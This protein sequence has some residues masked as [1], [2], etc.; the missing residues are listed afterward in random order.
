MTHLL[1]GKQSRAFAARGVVRGASAQS[2][3]D[4]QEVLSV[5]H[6]VRQFHPGIGGMENFVEQLA[7]RQRAAGHFVRVVTLDRIFDDPT[8]ARLPKAEVRRGIEIV[9]LPF[10]GSARYSIAPGVL[11]CIR[12]ADIVHVHGV[13]FFCD[14]LAATSWLHQKPMVISTHG[15]FFH[16]NFMRRF[17]QFYFNVATRSSMSQYGAVIACSEEDRRTFERVAGSRLTLIS[18]PVDV[19]KFAG[20]AD[21]SARNLIYFGRLAPNKELFRLIAWF[22]GLVSRGDWR[23]IIAG[24]P[25]GISSEQLIGEARIKG[26]ADRLEVHEAPTD[27]ILADLISRSTAYC[28]SSSY[29]GFGLAAIEAASAGLFPVL[30]DIPAFRDNVE[31]LGFGILIDF[32]DSSTWETSYERF[33]RSLGDFRCNLSRDD[34]RRKVA[35]F[36]WDGAAHLFEDVYARVLGRSTRRIGSVTVD[37]AD[38]SSATAAILD[39]AQARSPMMVT[40]CNAHTANLANSDAQLRDALRAA[41]VLNDGVGLD[42]ASRALFHA[43]FPENLNG[44]DF[45][46]QLLDSSDI[47]LRVYFIGGAK[48]VAEAA[49]H[50]VATRYP[51]VEVAGAA[52]GYFDEKESEGIVEAVRRSEANIVLLA[53]GQPRQEIWAARYYRQIAGPVVCVGALFDFLI[54]R[55][56]RAPAWMRKC[57]VEWAFRLM[58]EPLRL[59]G[60]YL[61]GNPTFLVRIIRQKWL[62]GRI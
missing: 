44:T 28:S 4:D 11:K 58:N 40:F 32:D 54:G 55:V 14:F 23:L 38:R 25:M 34:L 9:R 60:R 43:S 22:A 7:L 37:V 50:V 17:K 21:P 56:P 45:I 10:T 31:K 36:G 49:S 59:G 41:L 20:L 2:R 13:D 46:P 39:S 15:G 57:R 24:K 6:V 30:S 33:D 51:N 42:I 16:T 26:V 19:E 61:I 5:V 29:E 47:P 53:M 3:K 12:D 62:G 35:K 48:G 1:A 52:H 27:E 8:A 18:N